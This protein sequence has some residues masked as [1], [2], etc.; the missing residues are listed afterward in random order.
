MRLA[1][2]R[3]GKALCP[4]VPAGLPV[5]ARPRPGATLPLPV[6]SPQRGVA[7]DTPLGWGGGPCTCLGPACQDPA[8]ETQSLSSWDGSVPI[9]DSLGGAGGARA[10]AGL[11][12]RAG[13]LRGGRW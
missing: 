10:V 8:L 6:Y 2:E 7:A 11:A 1:R 4:Q 9:L 3:Q 13:E 5:V 12:W